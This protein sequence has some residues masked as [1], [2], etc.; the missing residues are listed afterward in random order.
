[1]KPFDADEII[2]AVGIRLED[3]RQTLVTEKDRI[4]RELGLRFAAREATLATREAELAAREAERETRLVRMEQA[5]A[6]K[7]AALKDGRDGEPGPAG[8]PGENGAPG[9]PGRDGSPG[10]DGRGWAARGAYEP[11]EAYRAG[12]IAWRDLSPFLAL[13]DDPGPCEER[14]VNWKLVLPKPSRGPQGRPGD[15][16]SPGAPGAPAPS[17]I[18]LKALPDYHAQL[19]LDDGTVGE[20]FCVRAWLE[21][22]HEEARR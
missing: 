7:L 16:G 5:I 8:P 19:V 11:G 2:R 22:Y 13:C 14:N 1:M 4:E 12:D 6:E 17:P 9:E 3:A 10:Q 21:Q 20:P 18:S 15:R